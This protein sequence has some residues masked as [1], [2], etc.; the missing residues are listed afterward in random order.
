M[1]GDGVGPREDGAG[2]SVLSLTVAEE[3]GIAGGI[4]VPEAAGLANETTGEAG[5]LGDGAVA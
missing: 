5:G 3:E 2:F 4:A 1:V